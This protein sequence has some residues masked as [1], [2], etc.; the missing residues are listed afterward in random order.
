MKNWKTRTMAAAL[1]LSVLAPTAGLASDALA[2]RGYVDADRGMAHHRFLNQEERQAERDRILDMVGKYTPD[3]L[4]EWKNA[5]GEREQ[6]FNALKEKRRSA[7]KER[8]QLSHEVKEKIKAI[9]EDVKNGKLTQEQAGA[10]MDKLGLKGRPGFDKNNLK[11]QYREAVQ[12]NDEAKIKELLP[13]M[14]QQLKERN[15]A[16]SDK[17]A[18]LNR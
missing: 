13:Q 16:L 8:P 9:G 10:E 11:V 15:Q 17:L 2:A 18:E 14:L 7:G 1:A 6:L 12:A 3:S 4:T 5:L